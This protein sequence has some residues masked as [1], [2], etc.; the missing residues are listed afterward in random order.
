MKVS[1]QLH[2]FA[3]VPQAKKKKKISI[4]GSWMGPKTRS[5]RCEEEKNVLPSPGIEP[6]FLDRPTHNPSL[7]SHF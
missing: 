5:G 6:Q 1:R 7:F 3:A 4:I 2:A